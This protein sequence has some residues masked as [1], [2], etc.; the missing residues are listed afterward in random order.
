MPTLARLQLECDHPLGHFR[1][2]EPFPEELETLADQIVEGYNH[3]SNLRWL[4]NGTPITRPQVSF[5]SSYTVRQ[6]GHYLLL[7]HNG[8][9]VGESDLRFRR[10]E[11]AEYG[12]LIADLAKQ[13]RGLGSV[14]GV[15]VHTLAFQAFGFESTF[16]QVL[17]GNQSSLRAVEKLGYQE[18]LTPW[19]AKFRID[20]GFLGF[21]LT[22]TRFRE[23]HPS[24]LHRMRISTRDKGGG[25]LNASACCEAQ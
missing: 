2:Y 25:I 4:P 10:N 16:A 12:V 18:A 9:W 21:G 20:E 3:P 15:M 1:V 23:L 6:G 5:H 14:F 19:W 24:T 13:G 8:Q 22:G 7:E 11:T 17:Q